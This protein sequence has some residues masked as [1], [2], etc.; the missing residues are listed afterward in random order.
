M[1]L[2]SARC[3]STSW[4]KPIQIQTKSLAVF[5]TTSANSSMIIIPAERPPM[6]ISKPTMG[7]GMVAVQKGLLASEHAENAIHSAYTK[8][9]HIAAV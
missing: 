9:S 6:S 7:F 3:G 1:L 5:G 4:P 2:Y 8:P